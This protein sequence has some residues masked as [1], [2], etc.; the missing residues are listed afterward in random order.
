MAA[1]IAKAKAVSKTQESEE[2][3]LRTVKTTSVDSRYLYSDPDSLIREYFL[4]S[5]ATRAKLRRLVFQDIK[6]YQS[7]LA[8]LSWS[9]RKEV[10]D[11]YDA[12]SDLLAECVDISFLKDA[13]Q[14]LETVTLLTASSS[15]SKLSDLDDFWEVLIKGIA[16]AYQIPVKDRFQVLFSLFPISNTRIFKAAIIDALVI[17]ADEMDDEMDIEQIKNSLEKFS[18]PHEQDLYI[19]HCAEEALQEIS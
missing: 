16:Y 18:T 6:S 9:R 10:S 2:V 4:S 5:P 14:Y 1:T 13:I 17:L 12:A 8:I 19:R 15:G 11:A 3:L 7:I